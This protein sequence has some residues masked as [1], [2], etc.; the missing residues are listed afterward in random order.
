M[1]ICPHYKK[2]IYLYSNLIANTKI[3]NYNLKYE[4]NI[5]LVRTLNLHIFYDK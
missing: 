4:S 2:Y 3:L 1:F 5:V